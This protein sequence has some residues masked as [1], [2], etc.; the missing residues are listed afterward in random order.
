M[1]AFV[2]IGQCGGGILD[3][4]F[5]EKNILGTA[6]A[7]AINSATSDLLNLKNIK[8]ENWLG[9]SKNGFMRG[10]EKGFDDIIA[11]GYGQDRDKAERDTLTHYGELLEY[12]SLHFLEGTADTKKISCAFVLFGLGGGTGSGAGPVVASSFRALGIPVIAI[13]V[14]PAGEE[15]SLAASNA[16]VS[17]KR[18]SEIANS[19][20]LIDNQR[21]AYTGNMAN[22]YRRYNDYVA[23]GLVELTLGSETE[24]IDPAAFAG[25]PPVID[26]NDIIT[27]TTLKGRVA[28]A[29]LAR[30]SERTRGLF[31][32]LFPIGGWKKIDVIKL[33]YESFLKLTVEGAKPED[34]EKNLALL[35][36]PPHYLES[37]GE[38]AP[39]DI[40]RAFLSERSSMKQTHLGVSITKRNLVSTVL[41]FTYPEEKVER[42]G[43][44]R[45]QAAYYKQEKAVPLAIPRMLLT[46][47][48]VPDSNEAEVEIGGRR[49]PAGSVFALKEGKHGMNIFSQ[50]HEPY[51][52]T[53]Q[54]EKHSSVSVGLQQKKGGKG[55]IIVNVVASGK[56]VKDAEVVIE[57]A[58]KRT[59][60]LGEG[61]FEVELGA[62][63]ITVVHP[64]YK[65]YEATVKCEGDKATCTVELN[66]KKEKGKKRKK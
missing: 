26:I 40:I 22:A 4:I 6:K 56:P 49:K 19:I 3:S 43:Q 35:R 32:Y 61:S 14:L 5:S 60:E 34:C 47:V 1:Y 21:I 65:V 37:S 62:H 52:G 7:L 11:G 38:L 42:I 24:R 63:K 27:A 15:G 57:N 30:S 17:L 13:A 44:L 53:L 28:Y 45:S 10:T 8:R 55:T 23:R 33:L 39:I 12:I 48:D 31:N 51:S 50:N 58:S 25:N 46:K 36:L 54:V 16:Y 9:L 41:L 66:P 2:S 20:I 29:C 59:S 18:V 64:N